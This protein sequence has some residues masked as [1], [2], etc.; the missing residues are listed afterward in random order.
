M[1]DNRHERAILAAIRA[2]KEAQRHVKAYRFYRK[3]HTH[4]E[5][6][7]SGLEYEYRL[8]KEM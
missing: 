3:V 6:A 2:V 1:S 4:L 8:S 7:L 5:E